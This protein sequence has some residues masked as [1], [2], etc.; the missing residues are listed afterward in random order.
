MKD[1]QPFQPKQDAR[2]PIVSP[3]LHC[4][5]MTVVVFLRRGFGYGY[6]GPKSVFIASSYAFVLFWIYARN[7]PGAWERHRITCLFGALVVGLYVY[8]LVTA[9]SD[10]IR[11]QARHDFHSGTSWLVTAAQALLGKRAADAERVVHLW[12]EP[13]LVLGAD[14]KS[15]FK[16]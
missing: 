8:H 12:V 7:E 11:S 4:L 2:I 1:R 14:R 9:I 15:T 13:L 16:M 3:I 6:L 10:L 5:S